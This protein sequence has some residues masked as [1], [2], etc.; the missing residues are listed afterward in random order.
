MHILN[1]CYSYHNTIDFIPKRRLTFKEFKS[2]FD[3]ADEA[4]SELILAMAEAG[5]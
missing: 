2:A 3:F 1:N 4:P 5:I